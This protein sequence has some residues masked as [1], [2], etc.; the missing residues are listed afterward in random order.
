LKSKWFTE[1]KLDEISTRHEDVF[2]K[3][4]KTQETSVSGLHF[5][6][7][8]TLAYEC[9]LFIEIPGLHA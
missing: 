4:L 5:F 3:S 9:E 6:Q 1:E 2:L 8:I 7:K